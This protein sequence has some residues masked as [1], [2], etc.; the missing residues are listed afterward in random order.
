MCCATKKEFIATLLRYSSRKAWLHASSDHRGFITAT[1]MAGHGYLSTIF[2]DSI[3]TTFFIFS[4]FFRTARRKSR[5]PT[6]HA[7]HRSPS[8]F[9]R[10]SCLRAARLTGCLTD[11]W[12]FCFEFETQSAFRRLHFSA[13]FPRWRSSAVLSVRLMVL[14]SF[15]P[16]SLLAS[17]PLHICH[18]LTSP[19]PTRLRLYVRTT[20]C[21]HMVTFYDH[22]VIC[23]FYK[24]VRTSR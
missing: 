16:F 18:C 1:A 5:S 7:T 6:G 15:S 23:D 12:Q 20:K 14:T 4:F 17:L 2:H 13:P 11:L 9:H 19:P 24:K 3:H 8:F 22:K 10:A 21:G